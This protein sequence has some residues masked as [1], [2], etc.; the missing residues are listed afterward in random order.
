MMRLMER[1]FPD[2][3]WAWWRWGLFVLG[4]PLWLLIGV[5][6]SAREVGKE[7]ARHGFSGEP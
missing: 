1:L 7:L 3:P 6:V 5:W 4:F 2:S